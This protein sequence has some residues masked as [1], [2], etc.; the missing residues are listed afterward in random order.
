MENGKDIS[1]YFKL[2]LPLSDL[3]QLAD[4]SCKHYKPLPAANPELTRLDKVLSTRKILEE[5]KSKEI[6]FS[7]PILK[8]NENAVFFSF[9]YTQICQSQFFT[10]LLHT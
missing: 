5:N 3:Q 1:D 7:K 10:F 4:E 2:G 6:T 9:L 8:Q